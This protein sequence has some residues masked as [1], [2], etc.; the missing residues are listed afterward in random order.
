MKDNGEIVQGTAIPL[1]LLYSR[2]R[3]QGKPKNLQSL[4]L[5]KEANF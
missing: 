1:P 4:P 2:L 5:R 3:S